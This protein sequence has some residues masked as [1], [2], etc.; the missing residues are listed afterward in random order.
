[1]VGALARREAPGMLS[2]LDGL[3]DEGHD[4]NQFWTELVAVIRDLLLLRSVPDRID[5]LSRSPEEGKA[6]LS[7]AEG[8]STE[9]LTRTFQLLADLE[10]ALKS[11]SR[12]RFMFEA[13]LI[14]LASLGAVQPIEQVLQALGEGKAASPAVSRPAPRAREKAQ[15]KKKPAGASDL[16]ERIVASVHDDKPVLGAVLEQSSRIAYREGVLTVAY[17]KGRE[18]VARP[19]QRRESLEVVR[20]H[21]ERVIGSAVEVRVAMPTESRVVGGKPTPPRKRPATPGTGQGRLLEQA[22]QEPGVS[23]LLREFGAQV[24]EIR[25]LSEP[26]DVG[27]GPPESDALEEPG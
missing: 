17:E 10:P 12:P 3:I 16:T 20:R 26:R 23:K 15:E 11:S 7:A 19:L 14:R 8:L 6:L 27:S 18:S 13:A 22:K 4:L 5:L 24:V 1:M 2:V 21:A 25:P 9:D